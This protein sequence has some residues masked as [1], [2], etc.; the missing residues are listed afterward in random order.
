MKTHDT[1]STPRG[2]PDACAVIHITDPRQVTMVNKAQRGYY[3]IMHAATP[4]EACEVVT[5][6]NTA[7]GV[8]PQQ[9]EAMQHG[10]MFGWH[11]PAA[12]PA[13]DIHADATHWPGAPDTITPEKPRK[14]FAGTQFETD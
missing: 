8:T 5:A 11:C 13:C 12:D 6:I 7:L 4:R 2:L 1:I 10:S 9:R 3:S 14:R